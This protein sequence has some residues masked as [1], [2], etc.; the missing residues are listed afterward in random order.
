MNSTNL[1]NYRWYHGQVNRGNTEQLLMGKEPGIYLVRDSKTST[2]DFVLSVS[3]NHKVSHYIINNNGNHYKI[4]DQTF[5]DIPSIISFYKNHFLDTTTLTGAVERDLKVRAIY[6]F[7]G[8]DPDDL[9]F[10]K[11]DILTIVSQDE[12]SWWTAENRIGQ[13]GSIPVP[14][15]QIINNDQPSNPRTPIRPPSTPVQTGVVN[16]PINT[17]VDPYRGGRGGSQ[18]R[19]SAPEPIRP[20]E[21]PPRPTMPKP[22]SGPLLA[23]AVIDRVCTPYDTNQIAFKKGDLIKVTKQNDN[24][25]WEG[26]LNGKTGEFPMS[27]VDLIDPNTMEPFSN[28]Y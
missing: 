21:I 24:G 13:R 16:P 6:N 10:Q 20:A 27:H 9:P 25:I 26:E 2:G 12:E 22:T 14:Y 5:A 4:G 23:R 8:R 3:E 1:Q 28:G 11:G 17:Y 15:V 18:H 19:N 7:E